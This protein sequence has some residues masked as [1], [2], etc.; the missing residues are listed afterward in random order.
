MGMNASSDGSGRVDAA[1]VAR[2][3]KFEVGERRTAKGHQFQRWV[4]NCWIRLR[5]WWIVADLRVG[6]NPV[7]VGGIGF[8]LPV[9][10]Y[11][12]LVS[13]GTQKVESEEYFH[14]LVNSTVT[15][16]KLWRKDVCHQ[17][18]GGDNEE[19]C[20]P[21]QSPV[22]DYLA[23]EII[24]LFIANL[25]Q[26]QLSRIPEPPR[27]GILRRLAIFARGAGVA[28]IVVVNFAL[29]ILMSYGFLSPLPSQT[30][31]WLFYIGLTVFMLA[32]GVVHP[33][34][35]AYVAFPLHPEVIQDAIARLQGSAS[36]MA[37]NAQWRRTALGS[38]I[39]KNE[40]LLS[41]MNAD[42]SD[43]KS[44]S[45]RFRDRLRSLWVR[46]KVEVGAFRATDPRRCMA[47]QIVRALLLR[48]CIGFIFAGTFVWIGYY[49][50]QLVALV[51]VT[52]IWVGLF[53]V[54]GILDSVCI[55]MGMFKF[56]NKCEIVFSC[57]AIFADALLLLG[58]LGT[59]D[60][61]ATAR[62]YMEN[63][64]HPQ[65]VAWFSVL[66]FVVSEVFCVLLAFEF[67]DHA[68]V[69]F[70]REMRRND[71]EAELLRGYRRRKWKGCRSSSR[72]LSSKGCR[73]SSWPLSRP[74]RAVQGRSVR[75]R[76]ER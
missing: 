58:A 72:R 14:F 26:G 45:V 52:V 40:K 16:A 60:M 15:A 30:S 42:K 51:S 70:V 37:K 25:A 50:Q 19:P 69:G 20:S 11:V 39:S 62:R 74:H 4:R 44:T 46:L 22:G 3:T 36:S 5:T 8:V 17:L 65:L 34:V 47:C 31:I 48:L 59:V 68:L 21:S 1:K 64:T 29:T 18:L 28:M 61:D 9:A 56:T 2:S 55:A 27:R 67:R 43:R 53:F 24:I 63:I 71:Y 7:L 57:F 76:R 75:V 13:M 6:A 33:L 49:V 38:K 32:A 35:K 12:F 41:S 73:R 23:L 10:V 54:C 66:L